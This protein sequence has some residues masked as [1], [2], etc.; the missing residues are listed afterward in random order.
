MTHLLLAAG[1]LGLVGDGGDELVFTTVRLGCFAES[2]WG[3]KSERPVFGGDF[4]NDWPGFISDREGFTVD[5][6][7]FNKDWP[8]LRGDSLRL[9][10][11]CP[12]ITSEWPGFI[13]MST[14]P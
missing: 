4:N 11:D 2:W 5:R 8:G 10:I 6:T 3:F 7:V 12:C 14:V 1:F 13:I 9:S